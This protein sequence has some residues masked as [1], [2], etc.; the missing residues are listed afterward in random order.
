ML[1]G[2]AMCVCSRCA[3]LYG[4]LALGFLLPPPALEDRSFRRLLAVALAAMGIDVAMQDAGLHAACH[5]VRLAT[6]VMVGWTA[7]AWMVRSRP[8]CTSD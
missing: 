2:E 1:G 5:P 3:G 7:A 4:G 6:G 8:P